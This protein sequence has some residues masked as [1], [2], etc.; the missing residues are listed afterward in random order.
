M[1]HDEIHL[2]IFLL[3]KLLNDTKKENKML[4]HVWR[5]V[6]FGRK[7]DPSEHV[8]FYIKYDEFTQEQIEIFAKKIL[9]E[10]DELYFS[11]QDV[12]KE[13]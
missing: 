7:L 2:L 3:E 4:V 1:R 13:V 10:N 9:V 11:L 6:F 8:P 12:W 5:V